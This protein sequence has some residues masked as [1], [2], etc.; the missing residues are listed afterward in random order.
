[1]AVR[2]RLHWQPSNVEGVACYQFSLQVRIGIF[3]YLYVSCVLQKQ[4]LL[5]LL[6]SPDFFSTTHDDD[7]ND[8]NHCNDCDEE[9]L[10]YFS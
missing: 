4:K 2:W 10:V 7:D 6:W 3:I 1:M 8:D 9:V 5:L